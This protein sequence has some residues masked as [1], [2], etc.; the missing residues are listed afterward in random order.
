MLL[1]G[2]MILSEPSRQA[3][4][5]VTDSGAPPGPAFEFKAE[6]LCHFNN[7]QQKKK[8]ADNAN[9]LEMVSRAVSSYADYCKGM[10]Y[11]A[12]ARGDAKA[13][14]QALENYLTLAKSLERADSIFNWRS[15]FAG[16]IIPEFIYRCLH[17]IFV[18]KNIPALFSTRDSVVELTLSGAQ[19]GGWEVRHKDQDLTIG[20]REDSIVCGKKTLTF[21]VPIVAMEVK[22]NIDINKL[23]GLD[24][25]AEGLKKTFPAGKYLL[26]TETIDFSLKDS[27]A[28]G[29]IDEVYVLRKQ[30]RSQARR[31]LGVLHHDVF[32]RLFLDV[33]ELVA[34]EVIARGHVYK[35]LE[36]GKL[37][38]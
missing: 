19:D 32:E 12:I 6:L 18:S 27:Y 34:A 31:Q 7:L 14:V 35:R 36:G 17:A 11:A 24:F 16:S 37:I 2:L 4:F 29:S 15:N 22:T 21:L 26:V 23:N 3:F 13:S 28:G 8:T 20:L 5:N 9:R 33:M 38:H 1:H 25:S 30:V 10:D